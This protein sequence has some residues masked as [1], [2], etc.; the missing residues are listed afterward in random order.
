MAW[1]PGRFSRRGNRS[2]ATGCPSGSATRSSASGRTGARNASRST[3]DWYARSMYQPGQCREY[4][5]HVEQY[6]HP[7][8]FGFKDVIHDWKA[9]K[10]DP[11]KL[12]AL[13]KRAGAKYFVAHG[14]PPRQ[15]RHCRTRSTSRGTRSTSARR[16]TSSAA[17]RRRPA[18]PA[19]AL[20][21]AST[22]PRLDLVSG[23]P[24]RRHERPARRRALRRPADQG[25]RQGPV[26]GG[27]RSA[28]PLRAEPQARLESSP[29]NWNRQSG[30]ST[31]LDQAYIEKF[32]NRT[33]DLVDKYQ[34]DLLYFDDTV[35]PIYRVSDIGLRIAAHFYNTSIARNGRNEAVMTG[36][37]PERRAAPAPGLRHRA[38][39]GQR[40]SSR[41]PGRPTPA[42]A[43]GT[44]TAA[45]SSSTGTRPPR[46]VVQMLVDIVSKNGNLLLSVPLRGD[47]TI[48]EDEVEIVEG[49]GAWMEVNG[50][51]IYATRPW[52][53]YGE[54]PVHRRRSREGPVRR[55]SATCERRTPPRTSVS[56]PRGDTLYAFVHGMARGRQSHHQDSRPGQR[57]LSQGHRTSGAV[58]AAAVRSRSPAP[59]PAWW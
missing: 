11:E 33:I 14:Q 39:R 17:G 56:R 51:G 20:A 34:P 27:P 59:Q 6:G 21:S 54:G 12:I 37:M 23:R 3:G 1:P 55:R 26:V 7:S 43:R 50:E 57:E 16:R 9:E 8:K 18:K 2:P 40:R 10:W 41:S 45:S 44:T 19:C 52:K 28:G 22:P 29:G 53:V 47:G 13:Y 24:G 4:K 32:F 5:F 42:S 25:R 15:L 35:L 48:D 38:R 36:K 31:P 46:Q 30:S 49:I 58:W